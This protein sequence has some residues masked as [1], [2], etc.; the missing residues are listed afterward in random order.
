MSV[1]ILSLVPCEAAN[2]ELLIEGL[3]VP[4]HYALSESTGGG[5][6]V[7]SKCGEIFSL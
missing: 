4:F 6:D 3:Y 7:G 1:L 2:E 5:W